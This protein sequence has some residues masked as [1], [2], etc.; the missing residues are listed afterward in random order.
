VSS[1][2]RRA[3]TRRRIAEAAARLFSVNGYT[4]TTVQAIAD[5]AGVHVQSVYQVFGSKVR[6]LAEAAAVLVAGPEEE[7]ATPPPERGW[8]LEMFAEPDPARQL[9][10]YVRNMREVSERYLRLVDI[11]RVTAANGP[12]VG[13]F[14]AQAEEGRYA[15]PA[16]LMRELAAKN[17]LRPGLTPGRAA[18]ITYAITGYDVFRT[19]VEER[20][21]SADETEVWLADTLATLLL[22]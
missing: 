15:G 1:T 22:A 6:V 17:A 8:V 21:W 14:L 19:L 20:G 10:L 11:M 9:A 16:H 18:D 7:A 5:A 13:R 2:S 4:D 3:V 12:D